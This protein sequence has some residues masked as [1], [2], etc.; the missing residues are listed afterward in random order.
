[1][2]PKSRRNFY[3]SSLSRNGDNWWIPDCLQMGSDRQKQKLP[4]WQGLGR[5]RT[6]GPS[7]NQPK[8]LPLLARLPKP[9]TDLSDEM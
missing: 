4:C 9:S 3:A 6:D 7:E 2:M 5:K 1:M 8:L